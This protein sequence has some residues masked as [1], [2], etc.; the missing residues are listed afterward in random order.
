MKNP[1]K[2]I[3]IVNIEERLKKSKGRKPLPSDSQGI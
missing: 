1:R 3:C 2:G